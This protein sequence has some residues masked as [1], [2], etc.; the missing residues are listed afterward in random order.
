[1][2]STLRQVLRMGGFKDIRF[3]KVREKLKL[4]P[5]TIVFRFL[6][7]LWIYVLK[8]IYLIERPGDPD[9]PKFFLQPLVAVA[10]K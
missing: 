10:K 9:N 8:L 6:K 3:V 4:H 1:M 5:K 2:E 7:R